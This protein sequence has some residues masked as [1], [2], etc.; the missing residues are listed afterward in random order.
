MAHRE[1]LV[2]GLDLG[3]GSVGWALLKSKETAENRLV[4]AGVRV[5]NAG[6]D[7][8]ERDGRGKSRNAQRRDARSIRRQNERRRRRMTKLANLLQRAGLLPDGE[9][10]ISTVR[11]DVL[12]SLDREFGCPYALRDRATRGVI[13]L[14][15][16]GRALYQLAQRRGFLSNRRSAPKDGEELGAVKEGCTKLQTEME[17]ANCKSLGSYFSILSQKRTRLRGRYTHRQMFI[18]E[19][20]MIW[21]RQAK[22]YP[23]ILKPELRDQIFDAIFFQRPLKIQKH[24]VGECGLEKGQSRAPWCLLEAQRFRYM[25]TV[26]NLRIVNT[27][28]GE[29]TSLSDEQR[30]SGYNYLEVTKKASFAGLR[31][32]MKLGRN[33]KFT[34]E[35]EGETKI[36]GN[37]TAATIS[38]IIG[39]DVWSS[40]SAQDQSQ[41]VEDLRS[42]RD[43]DALVRRLMKAYHLSE[44]DSKRLSRV[45]LTQ[46]YCRYSR[47]A[48]RRILPELEKGISLQTAIREVYPE[49]WDRETE[50][51]AFLPPLE[52]SGL[53]E[54]RNP[55][56][57]RTLTELRKVVNAIIREYGTPEHIHIEFARELRQTAKQRIATTKKMRRNQKLRE[58]AATFLSEECGIDDPSRED[59][60]KILLWWECNEVCPYTGAHISIRQLIGPNPRFDIEH[61]I[62]YSKSL[63]DSFL[64]K[65]LCDAEENRNTKRNRTPYEAYSETDRWEVILERVKNFSGDTSR[66]KLRRF[67]MTP[68]DVRE[69]FDDFIARQLNDT[70]WA[71]KWGK[72]YLGLLYGG[73]NTDGVDSSG[74]RRVQTSSGQLTAVL[75]YDWGLN[76]ILSATDMKSRDDHRHHTIDA[77]VVAL[78]TPGVIKQFAN[79]ARKSSTRG[80]R[81]VV[82]VQAPWLHF[83]EDVHALVNSVITSHAVSARVRGAMHKETFYSPSFEENGQEYVHLRRQLFDLKPN[84]TENIVDPVIKQLVVSKLEELKMPPAKAFSDPENLPVVVHPDGSKTM[85]RHVRVR[86]NRSTIKIGKAER[87]RFVQVDSNHHVEYYRKGSSGKNRWACKVLGLFEAYQRTRLR[88]PIVSRQLSNDAD[89]LFSLSKN[90]AIQLETDDGVALYTVLKLPTNGQI[91][92][93]PINDSRSWSRIPHSGLTAGPNALMAKK[94]KKVTIDLL[95]RVR[96]ASN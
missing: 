11:H 95:G 5:F 85:V 31:K 47:R 3:T 30:L 23:E 16:L 20:E 76:G 22:F 17:E 77:I 27:T 45:S 55:V 78:S 92:F 24:L 44:D 93:V 40:I 18:D 33:T 61:I 62:P 50:P 46:G 25:Q 74:K 69:S 49:I 6:L 54:L 60:L 68:A 70:R 1:P 63:D 58:D 87:A 41:L 9:L 29:E 48:L 39:K 73:I 65:T 13:P 38:G 7:D 84:E 96:R 79:S 26:N 89:F 57:E 67:R 34:I 14:H 4:A 80:G 21:A 64:N 72:Q 43:D 32:E 82:E 56:V 81:A 59:I 51:L 66:A 19:F 83:R 10:S 12:N 90:E 8:L 36:L 2:L 52:K 15:A 37:D 75:R 71:T 28:T 94:C 88:C 53:P 91:C 35:L 42:I 86:F